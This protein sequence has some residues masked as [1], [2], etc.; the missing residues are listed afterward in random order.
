MSSP[1]PDPAVV[2]VTGP[3]GLVA[4]VPA[5]LGFTPTE[6][7][8]AVLLHGSRVVATMRCDVDTPPA[9]ATAALAV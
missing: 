3:A 5:L 6:S 1:A 8:V 2:H 4:S 7:L 9:H